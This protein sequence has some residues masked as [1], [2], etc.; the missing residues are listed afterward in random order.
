MPHEG[1]GTGKLIR[2]D[3]VAYAW[4][5]LDLPSAD[6]AEAGYETAGPL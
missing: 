6:E 3:L 2:V 1:I 5:L 4:A